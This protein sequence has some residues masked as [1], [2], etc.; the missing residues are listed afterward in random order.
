M[1]VLG[2]YPTILG[3][4]HIL[5]TERRLER[6]YKKQAAT[7]LEYDLE[8]SRPVEEGR[9]LD[10]LRE[11]DRNKAIRDAINRR[12]LRAMKYLMASQVAGELY[13]ILVLGLHDG[14]WPWDYISYLKDGFNSI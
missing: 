3:F 4:M 10:G 9:V 5:L 7:F 14:Y 13:R 1:V 6:E 2:L 12:G 11:Q 8:K